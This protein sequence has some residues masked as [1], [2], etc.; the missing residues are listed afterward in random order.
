MTMP[1]GMSSS[2]QLNMLLD[3][4]L[5]SA[6][7]PGLFYELSQNHELQ[8][9]MFELIKLKNMMKV[10]QPAPKDKLKAAFAEAQRPATVEVYA[11][12]NHGWTVPGSQ[13][14]NEASAEKA[15]GELLALY[16]KALG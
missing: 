2:E 5:H 9:E 6:E 13:A 3:G 15:W 12:A 1:Y 16:K 14:Y 7:A 10:Q 11:G 4:E 8:E